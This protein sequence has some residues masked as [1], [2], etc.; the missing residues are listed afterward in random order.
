MRVTLGT[1]DQ[2]GGRKYRPAWFRAVARHYAKFAWSRLPA[3][4]KAPTVRRRH[5][6]H[7]TEQ[8]PTWIHPAYL[9]DL[10]YA[11]DWLLSPAKRP[12]GWPELPWEALGFESWSESEALAAHEWLSGGPWDTDEFLEARLDNHDDELGRTV[13]ALRTRLWLAS[14]HQGRPRAS[15]G[16]GRHGSRIAI[17]A[18]SLQSASFGTRGIGRFAA[19]V[20]AGA[21]AAAG[22]DRVTLIVDR[23][24]DPLPDD[25]AGKCEQVS[26]VRRSDDFA[27]LLQP[28]PMTHSP[29]PLIPLLDGAC[30]S[31]ALV[32]DF[33]PLHYPAVYLNNPAA[34]AEYAGRLEALRLYRHFSAI[35][36]TVAL[37]MSSVLPLSDREAAEVSVVWPD[38]VDRVGEEQ[39]D[40]RGRR[41]PI[42]VMTGDEPRKNTFG[43]LAGVAAATSDEPARDV[44]VLGMAGQGVR[45]H[46]WSIGAAMRPGEAVTAERISDEE[47]ST[48]LSTARCVVVPS[49]DEGLS[50]PV[51]E[52]VRAGAPV[53]A[54][55]I[56]AHF[57]L[58]GHG[59]FLA[60]PASPADMCRAIRAVLRQP[61]ICRSQAPTLAGHSHGSLER[62]I[63]TLVSAHPHTEEH[64][65]HRQESAGV[66]DP[67]NRLRVALATP[68][69]PQTSGVADFSTTIGIELAKVCDL[70]VFTTS[71]AIVPDSLPD[72]VVMQQRNVDELIANPERADDFDAVITVV[73]NSHFHLPFVQLTELMDTYA[74]AHDTRMVEFYLSMRDRHGVQEVMLRSQDRKERALDPALDDQ[75]ADMRLLQNAGLWEVARRS[76]RLVI[77][78]PVSAPRIERETGVSP[79]VLPF[80]NQRV[81][82]HVDAAA[83][84]QARERLG[85]DRW[86]S[87]VI[88]LA[89]FGFVDIR[90]KRSDLVV[91]AAAWLAQWGRSVM[92]HL[93]GAANSELE[94]ALRARAESSDLAGLN[95]TGFV[96]EQTFR[97]YLLAIDVGVQLRISPLLGVSGPLSDLAASGT[98]AVASEGLCLDVRAPGYVTPVPEMASPVQIAEALERCI[99]D[100]MNT[101]ELEIQRRAYLAAMSPAAYARQ[102]VE[103]VRGEK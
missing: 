25:L 55:D 42:V 76:T 10:E 20:V 11:C 33:I 98:P 37:E 67:G 71:D 1:V 7:V 29:R 39:S 93:V 36:N 23:G 45:V 9:G 57:E 41:G 72:G 97:D 13:S 96:D 51:I 95:V 85:F 21:R 59:E 65:K 103:L 99:D 3:P 16:E 40:S 66:S 54:S 92:L 27:L 101:E 18:R 61:R 4:L 102:L 60:D 28:S 64:H 87:Y 2:Q 62:K 43:G 50:L 8:M 6:S 47:M 32:F 30:D 35:S 26:R 44:V 22:D 83:R 80:A 86:G 46:H 53:V 12:V 89:S 69:A 73:G 49:F 34:R 14:M 17:D 24:L 82:R 31:W 19:S 56:P 74:V 90:T 84:E 70:T 58:I 77:H 52:A 5:L 88:H 75:I 91:E 15:D 78:S 68:W 38:A 81:P 79:V 100:P 94:R 48:L 63:Q